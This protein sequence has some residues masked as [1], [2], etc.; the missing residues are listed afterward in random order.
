MPDFLLTDPDG[1]RFKLTVPDGVSESDIHAV[2]AG[3]GLPGPAQRRSRGDILGEGAD[4]LKEALAPS[5]LKDTP[6]THE[7]DVA[8]ADPA[9]KPRKIGPPSG[10]PAAMQI[11]GGLAS[12]IASGIAPEGKALGVAG[13]IGR[14]GL[15]SPRQIRSH[16]DEL[17]EAVRA[18][19]MTPEQL[20]EARVRMGLPRE[21]PSYLQPVNTRAHYNRALSEGRITEQEHRGFMEALGVPTEQQVVRRAVQRPPLVARRPLAPTEE[22]ARELLRN[23]LG[24]VPAGEPLEWA[25]TYNLIPGTE[26]QM[27]TRAVQRPPPVRRQYDIFS[28]PRHDDTEARSLFETHIAKHYGDPQNFLQSYFNGAWAS[29]GAVRSK[30]YVDESGV[31]GHGLMFD[32]FLTDADGTRL[33]G[34]HREIYPQQR[35]ARHEFLEIVESSRGSGFVKQMTANQV[36]AYRKFGIEKVSLLAD[37]DVGS[38]A[39]AKYGWLPKAQ[40]WQD[41]VAWSLRERLGQLTRQGLVDNETEAIIRAHLNSPD[42]RAIWRIS[43][44]NTAFDPSK[45]TYTGTYGR[46]Y[47]SDPKTNTVGKAMLIGKSWGGDLMLNSA[48]QMER[49]DHYVGR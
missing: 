16:L 13:A 15:A 45:W 23:H 12:D 37:I 10:P 7:S 19:R 21:V 17:N 4:T 3:D 26:Q 9:G 42:P 38:Y 18:G 40:D 22:Q 48:E 25:R 24:F 47:L 33:G 8:L 34:I 29:D 2:L 14:R 49:F 20:G 5:Y 46:R 27:V 35:E 1:Q 30:R 31:R 11:V 28:S 6:P 43:D 32:G 44:S 41:K 36:E 39:W